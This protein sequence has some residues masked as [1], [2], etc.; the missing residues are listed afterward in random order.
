MCVLA[1]VAV[2][3]RNNQTLAVLREGG[4]GV[5]CEWHVGSASWTNGAGTNVRSAG[6]PGLCLT[7][8]STFWPVPVGRNYVIQLQSCGSGPSAPAPQRWEMPISGSGHITQSSGGQCLDAESSPPSA[9]PVRCC[10]NATAKSL[11]YC[12]SSL[13]PAERAADLVS[14]LT[15]QEISGALTMQ[16]MQSETPAGTTKVHTLPS[17]FCSLHVLISTICIGTCHKPIDYG[18]ALHSQTQ[19]CM[20]LCCTH[21]II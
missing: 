4:T 17:V 2:Y 21:T 12:S 13:S 20:A 8:S 16:L 5:D 3:I 18:S 19:L 15:V 14:R 10:D 7:A 6:I 9:P 1:N 11:P